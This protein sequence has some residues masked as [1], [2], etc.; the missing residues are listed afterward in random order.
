LDLEELALRNFLKKVSY[1]I[2]ILSLSFVER[3]KLIKLKSKLKIKKFEKIKEKNKNFLEIKLKK[4]KNKMS[5]MEKEVLNALK[6]KNIRK[7]NAEILNALETNIKK[8]INKLN[9]TTRLNNKNDLLQEAKI[10]ILEVLN[11]NILNEIKCAKSTYLLAAATNRIKATYVKEIAEKRL[12]QTNAC[13]LENLCEKGGGNKKET[14]FKK[15]ITKDEIL[16]KAIIKNEI[17]IIKNKLSKR[18]KNI[19]SLL[20]MGNTYLEIARKLQLSI[21]IVKAIIRRRIK[22][23]F[24]KNLKLNKLYGI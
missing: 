12:A 16:K 22:P 19:L 24:S 11:K 17:N 21:F 3:D 2:M 14:H 1:G 20:I 23:I 5:I 8:I 9:L 15:K 18:E 7:R 4:E 6:N 13:S 10:A